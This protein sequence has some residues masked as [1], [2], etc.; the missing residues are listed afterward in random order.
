[1][2]LRNGLSLVELVVVIV[3]L[4]LLFAVALPATLKIRES[5]RAVHCRNNLRQISLGF[6]GYESSNAHF[7]PGYLGVVQVA[8]PHLG[9]FRREG[10]LAGHLLHVLSYLESH[11]L[12]NELRRSTPSPFV[13]HQHLWH[14][15]VYAIKVQQAR[16]RTLECP[17]VDFS[18][19]S[20]RI[21]A[22]EP[23]GSSVR[24]YADSAAP[25]EASFTSYLGNGGING[26]NDQTPTSDLG[27]FYVNSRV[28]F[29]DI[30]DGSTNTIL[31]G[32]TR[33]AASDR[34]NAAS[35]HYPA[36]SPARTADGFFH[37]ELQL[38]G[39]LGG[40]SSFGSFHPNGVNLSFCDGSTKFVADTTNPNIVRS[41]STVAGL[42]VGENGVD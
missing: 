17:S 35:L 39:S 29:K 41:L 8:E 19:P 20:S 9:G 36:S 37:A 3:I 31:V 25:G 4:G 5:G 32:E 2:N 42:D 33:G 28:R 14:E 22:M 1:M 38:K 21:I 30:R 23:W 6:L 11:N 26:R 24:Y 27:V 15:T 7:P 34:M 40:A 16:I 12:A 10:S 18:G 13:P